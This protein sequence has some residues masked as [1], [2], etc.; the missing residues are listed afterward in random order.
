MALSDNADPKDASSTPH[1]RPEGSPSSPGSKRGR[2]GLAWVFS[3]LAAVVTVAAAGGLV[4]QIKAAAVPETGT[5]TPPEAYPPDEP[6]EVVAALDQ[7]APVPDLAS[8]LPRLLDDRRFSGDLSAAFA[9]ATTGEVLFEQDGS[10]PMTPASSMKVVTGVA[11]F[12][13][14]GPEFRIPTTVVEGPDDDSV[15]LVAGGDVAMTVDGQ[16]YYGEGASL[17]ELAEAVLEARDGVAPSTVYLDT[18]IFD[19]K[20][21]A[22]GVP[23]SDLNLYTAPAAPIMIDGGRIDNS[24]QYTPHH[25]DP[26][27]HAAEVFAG[28]VG[29]ATAVEGT[30]ADGAAELA[31]V[32]SEPLT[33]LVDSLILSS[34]NELA[35]AVGFQTALAVEGEMTWDALGRAHMATLE[36]L[37]VDTTGLVLNDGSG[38][39]PTNRLTANAFTQL[40][41]GAAASEASM[42]FESLPVAGYSGS[43]LQRFG[44]AT[45]GNGV[46]RAKT[47][48]LSGVSSLTGSVMTDDGRLIV[49]SMISNDHTNAQAVET[50][51]DEV[52]AAVSQC[53]C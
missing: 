28:L 40:L 5:F 34:D 16:G 22:D 51:M 10:T 32:H 18:G 46:V 50:A 26:A 3:I 39:S 11:A 45:E 43:L 13:H 2:S 29:A 24:E 17:T 37:G 42:V 35:D 31:T 23:M 38:M 7:G 14:L 52:T 33:A 6:P 49:F 20:V 9:D 36:S 30:A 48:T 47:G 41:M 21:N 53:G 4:W 25:R 19:D 27:M 15:V 44:T 8:L 12:E 1:A